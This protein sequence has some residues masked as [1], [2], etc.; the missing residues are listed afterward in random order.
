MGEEIEIKGEQI[1]QDAANFL[2][3]SK[4]ATPNHGEQGPGGI[5]GLLMGNA[6]VVAVC[7]EIT[8]SLFGARC[9]GEAIG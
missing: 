7:L 4:V 3:E 9:Q 1:L 2:K 6:S 5:Q 8:L